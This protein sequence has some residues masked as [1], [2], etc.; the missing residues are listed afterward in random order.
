MCEWVRKR[1]EVC[2]W[3]QSWSVGIVSFWSHGVLF[4]LCVC[5]SVTVTACVCLWRL[6]C[7]CVCA[8]V[9]FFFGGE[10]R[11]SGAWVQNARDPELNCF[12]KVEGQMGA[13]RTRVQS[14]HMLQ[15]SCSLRIYVLQSI[16]T[17][18]STVFKKLKGKLVRHENMA[19]LYTCCSLVAACISIS[20][21]LDRCVHKPRVA[22]YMGWLRLVGSLK[23]W[24]SFADYILFYRAL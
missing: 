24:V 7:M 22:V 12:Q 21:S 10:G 18:N 19:S 11:S 5:V 2:L 6:V 13:S 9:C 14:M 20:C 3:K 1:V 16:E 4:F 23:L 15:S 17:R 8:C